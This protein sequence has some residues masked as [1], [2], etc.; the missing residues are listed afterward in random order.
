[1]RHLLPERQVRYTCLRVEQRLLVVRREDL[2]A[3]LPE[4]GEEPPG[5]VEQ[6]PADGVVHAVDVLGGIGHL[7]RDGAELVPGPVGRGIGDAGGGEQLLV[8]DHRQVVD[9]NGESDDLAAGR[10]DLPGRRVEVVPVISRLVDLAHQVH[11]LTTLGDVGD[12]GPVD[13]RDVG[14]GAGR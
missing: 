13:V 8:V 11:S 4:P 12:V 1:G 7:F 3:A 5:R 2:P 6:I 14:C 9:E 10:H